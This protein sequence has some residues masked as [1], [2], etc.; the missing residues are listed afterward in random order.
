VIKISAWQ[1]EEGKWQVAGGKQASGK[2]ASGK[3]ASG[4]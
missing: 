2:Q 1:K 4:K 3:W